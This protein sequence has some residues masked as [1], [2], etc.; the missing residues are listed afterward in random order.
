MQRELKKELRAWTT[1]DAIELYNVKGWGR[2]FFSVNVRGSAHLLGAA[3][4]ASLR[5][6][7]VVSSNSPLGT[8]PTR[9]DLFDES[10]SYRP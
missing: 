2:D 1:K 3:K 8:N 9:G 7:V 10:S 4:R 5:R 6:V